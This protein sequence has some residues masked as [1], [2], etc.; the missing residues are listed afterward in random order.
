MF[1]SPHDKRIMQHACHRACSNVHYARYSSL[2]KAFDDGTLPGIVTQHF[3]VPALRTPLEQVVD[4]LV[5][6]LE[7]ADLELEVTV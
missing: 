3:Q 6:H 4:F 5:V 2:R 1:L 7:V